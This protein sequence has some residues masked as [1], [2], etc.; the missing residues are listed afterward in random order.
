VSLP[1]ECDRLSVVWQNDFNAPPM[2]WWMDEAPT[3]EAPELDLGDVK[4]L[5][6]APLEFEGEV[7][8]AAGDV[9]ITA[10]V[11]CLPGVHR[12]D[13]P[14]VLSVANLHALE[15]WRFVFSLNVSGGIRIAGRLR[16][17]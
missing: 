4:N 7:A 11:G 14:F 2:H 5:T 1:T 8:T 12:Q 10:F 17:T 3:W 9:Q 13:N 16:C 6:V 15:Q